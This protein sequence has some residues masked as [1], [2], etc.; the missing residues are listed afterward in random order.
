MSY[1]VADFQESTSAIT[2]LRCA[3]A[4]SYSATTH[5]QYQ[6]FPFHAF[7]PLCVYGTIKLALWDVGTLS[8]WGVSG[9][10]RPRGTQKDRKRQKKRVA[11]VTEIGDVLWGY[12][13]YVLCLV[14]KVSPHVHNTRQNKV[15]F[16][17]SISSC[18]SFHLLFSIPCP[19]AAALLLQ[20]YVKGNSV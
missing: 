20:W 2:P 3:Y 13:F 9:E 15:F 6:P 11:A 16:N 19:L 14:H 7:Q 1:M 17:I 4:H 8:Q 10:Y 5:L 12:S 18:I